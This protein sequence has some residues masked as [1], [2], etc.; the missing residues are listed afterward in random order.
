MYADM[1]P[2]LQEQK[3]EF[4]QELAADEAEVSHG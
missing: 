4:I 2:T 1:P 3:E